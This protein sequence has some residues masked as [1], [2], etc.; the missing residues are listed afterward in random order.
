M[1]H[2]RAPSTRHYVVTPLQ[3][4]D[5]RAPSTR[6]LTRPFNAMS[7][8]PFNTLLRCRTPSMHHYVVVLLQRIV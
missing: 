7:A 6:H 1:Q 3:R 2:R 8:H 5:Q 4:V